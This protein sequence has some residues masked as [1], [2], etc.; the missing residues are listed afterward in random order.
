M[1]VRQDDRDRPLSYQGERLLSCDRMHV[2]MR[3]R[4]IF[5]LAIMWE[6]FMAS[7]RAHSHPASVKIVFLGN[8]PCLPFCGSRLREFCLVLRVG[9]KGKDAVVDDVDILSRCRRVNESTVYINRT[10]TRLLERERS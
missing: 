1:L 8:V 6:R 7:D 3:R 10:R 9:L 2:S 5:E 4:I